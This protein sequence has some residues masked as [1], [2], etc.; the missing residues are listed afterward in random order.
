VTVSP[1]AVALIIGWMGCGIV[2]GGSLNANFR[3]E[4]CD[5]LGSGRWAAQ[6]LG[7][8]MLLGILGGPITLI[9]S[10]FITGGVYDGVT[11][12][13]LPCEKSRFGGPK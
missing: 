1:K 11:F 6:N 8:S 2:A 12:S 3:G 13:A 5:N 9:I 4:F 10:A 7:F